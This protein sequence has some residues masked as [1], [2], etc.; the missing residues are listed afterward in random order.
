M[1]LF[2]EYRVGLT[3]QNQSKYFTILTKKAKTYNQSQ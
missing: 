3:L 1:D 2:Q